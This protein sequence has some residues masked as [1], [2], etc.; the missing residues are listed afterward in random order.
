MQSSV[1]GI[2]YKW[3][4]LLK[5]EVD[6]AHVTAADTDT[7]VGLRRTCVLLAA[8]IIR[9]KILDS[10]DM[11]ALANENTNYLKTFKPKCHSVQLGLFTG[12]QS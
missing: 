10:K 9:A 3:K 11:G 12:D 8:N 4:N 7:A 5:W 1:I 6:Y 2:S